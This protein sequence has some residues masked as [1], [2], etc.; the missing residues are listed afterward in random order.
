MAKNTLKKKSGKSKS[1][2]TSYSNLDFS[3]GFWS[4]KWKEALIIPFLAF[5]LYW[6]SLSFGYVLDDQIVITDNE[7]TKEGF[8]GIWD[9]LSTE[10]FTGYFGS[11]KDLVAGARYRPLSIVTFAIEQEIFGDNSFIRHF[12]NILLYGLCGLLIFRI[13][14]ILIPNHNYTPSILKWSQISKDVM[15]S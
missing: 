7:F 12:G 3:P 10:S 14:S 15:K 5:A 13:L 4:M 11:Q 6:M 8:S 2:Q 9:I 1:K